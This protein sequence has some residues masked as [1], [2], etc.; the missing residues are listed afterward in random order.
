MYLKLLFHQYKRAS[1]VLSC[2][3]IRMQFSERQNIQMSQYGIQFLKDA[4]KNLSIPGQDPVDVQFVEGGYLFLASD[5]GESI[6]KKNF[7]TQWYDC[8]R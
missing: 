4:P 5:R 1:A 2:G 8:L 7:A 3:G 6:L